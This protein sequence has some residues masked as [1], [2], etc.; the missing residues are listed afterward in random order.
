MQLGGKCSFDEAKNR[1][2]G[3]GAGDSNHSK[4]CYGRVDESF[5]SL[6]PP[7]QWALHALSTLTSDLSVMYIIF[8][9]T[10]L[11]LVMGQSHHGFVHIHM[12]F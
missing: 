5:F 12:C 11:I 1:P 4:R 9:V 6:N 2:A 10:N 7:V 3:F 8:H